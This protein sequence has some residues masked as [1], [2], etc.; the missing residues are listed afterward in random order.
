MKVSRFNSVQKFNE[1][2]Y[3]N[4]DNNGN[5]AEDSNNNDKGNKTRQRKTRFMKQITYK[6]KQMQMQVQCS[7]LILFFMQAE[8]YKHLTC[9]MQ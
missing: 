7:F 6:R 4:Y 9:I 5:D 3:D 8:S 1:N 2:N